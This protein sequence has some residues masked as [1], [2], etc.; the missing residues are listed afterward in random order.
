VIITGVIDVEK[1]EVDNP[2]TGP[3]TPALITGPSTPALITGPSTPA[4]ESWDNFWATAAEVPG[5]GAWVKVWRTANITTRTRVAR[6]VFPPIIYLV[7]YPM[8]SLFAALGVIRTLPLLHMAA[9]QD[10]IRSF[11]ITSLAVDSDN[12]AAINKTN[13]VVDTT[14]SDTFHV[15]GTNTP[16]HLVWADQEVEFA[17]TV[18]PTP[19][20]KDAAD[21]SCGNAAQLPPSTNVAQMDVTVGDAAP[22]VRTIQLNSNSFGAP[23]RYPGIGASD[24][25]QIKAGDDRKT[26]YP[27]VI[28]VSPDSGTGKDLGKCYDFDVVLYITTKKLKLETNR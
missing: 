3:S 25:K 26:Q 1:R 7:I 27:M 16:R 12:A 21:V 20:K 2:T 5:I 28:Q 9:V 4:P 14:Y 23:T 15:P 11:V 13:A 8:I 22:I 10:S 6:M 17:G 19:P 18:T 24:W